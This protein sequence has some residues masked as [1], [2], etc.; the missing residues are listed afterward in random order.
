[1]QA[2]ERGREV[3]IPSALIADY[4]D[5]VERGTTQWDASYADMFKLR[6]RWINGEPNEEGP[7]RPITN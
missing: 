5:W 7:G 3:A 1:M 6:A 2:H 4:R